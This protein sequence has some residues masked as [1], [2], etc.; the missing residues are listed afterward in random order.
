MQLG[1]DLLIAQVPKDFILKKKSFVSASAHIAASASP[2]TLTFVQAYWMAREK[3]TKPPPPVQQWTEKTAPIS[4]P[5]ESHFPDEANSPY[6]ST[7]TG[8]I[9]FIGVTQFLVLAALPL[10]T[11]REKDKL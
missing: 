9:V 2:E 1:D 6:R 4:L 3:K 10:V 5:R 11:M 7:M 8:K